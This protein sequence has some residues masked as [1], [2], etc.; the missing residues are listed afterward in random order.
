MAKV[1]TQVQLVNEINMALVASG[2]PAIPVEST[3][4]PDFRDVNMPLRVEIQA[5][6]EKV[7]KGKTKT[8]KTKAKK[9]DRNKA[10]AEVIA[11]YLAANYPG[12]KTLARAVMEDLISYPGW[13]DEN[14]EE[15]DA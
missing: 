3:S 8:E 2:Q 13:E 9:A 7:A 4:S 6:L 15:D 12:N 5:L 14:E 11:E 10:R 1:L